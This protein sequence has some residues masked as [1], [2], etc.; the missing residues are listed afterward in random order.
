LNYGDEEGKVMIC[1][2]TNHNLSD[3]L[4]ICEANWERSL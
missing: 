1:A 2:S 4:Q 3:E